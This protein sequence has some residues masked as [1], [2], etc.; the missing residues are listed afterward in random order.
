MP[1][2]DRTF[3]QD[4][5]PE[6]ALE[7]KERLTA[8]RARH[9][10]DELPEVRKPC[11]GRIGDILRPLLQAVMLASPEKT[12]EFTA[13]CSQLEDE[14]REALADT[15]EAKLVET[16]EALEEQVYDGK[17]DAGKITEAIN[18]GKPEKFQRSQNTVTRTLKGMG[19]NGKRSNG[20]TCIEIDESLLE[21]LRTRYRMH[22]PGK[23]ALSDLSVYSV[24]NQTVTQRASQTDDRRKSESALATGNGESCQ[25]TSE[26][27]SALAKGKAHCVNAGNDNVKTESAESTENQKVHVPMD[28]CMVEE[29]I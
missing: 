4:V 29:T 6:G 27:E 16:I 12:E 19:F 5:K 17:L 9:L 13:F 2:S 24:E 14:R 15:F 1:E 3:D 7:L 25:C 20:V 28:D 26:L 18:A 11:R 21:K 8:F 23:S 10:F 22:T